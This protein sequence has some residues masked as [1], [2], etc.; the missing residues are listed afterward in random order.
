MDQ[1]VEVS[2]AFRRAHELG[3]V[4]S[5][6]AVRTAVINKR[7]GGMG[8]PAQHHATAMSRLARLQKV[9]SDLGDKANL[10]A[11]RLAST[12]SSRSSQ[13]VCF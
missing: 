1:H 10:N 9:L 5:A 4:T 7:A 2:R 6:E 3:L 11:E 12:A 13:D 8:V